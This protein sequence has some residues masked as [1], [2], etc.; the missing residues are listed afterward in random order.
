M[1]GNS[2]SRNR[3][4]GE[5]RSKSPPRSRNRSENG[6]NETTRKQDQYDKQVED[7]LKLIR[8]QTNSEPLQYRIET[9]TSQG[10]GKADAQ[11]YIE[12]LKTQEQLCKRMEQNANQNNHE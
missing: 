9:Y 5:K 11:T 4:E 3:N 8:E 10:M 6:R 1:N 12:C 2:R 7:K